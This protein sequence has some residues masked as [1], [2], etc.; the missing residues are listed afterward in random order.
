MNRW[1]TMWIMRLSW[2]C[3]QSP[4][5]ALFLHIPPYFAWSWINTYPYQYP[6]LYLYT[7][8]SLVREFGF[9]TTDGSSSKSDNT[10]M[11]RFTYEEKV[12]ECGI[13]PNE[14]DTEFSC[15]GTTSYIGEAPQI[16]D[17]M[18]IQHT[19][20]PGM[21]VD[22][23]AIDYAYV[24]DRIG[25]KYV[26]Y[27]LTDAW[28][29]VTCPPDSADYRNPECKVEL[30][31]NDK[32]GISSGLIMFNKANTKPNAKP[33]LPCSQTSNTARMS[34]F[35]SIFTIFCSFTYKKWENLK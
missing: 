26:R 33:I 14:V 11:V 32:F 34:V 28:G 2:K 9:H 15:N 13:V 8:G 31:L 5:S 10:M 29:G 19:G 27:I 35:I 3:R 4:E 22:G 21:A 18:F 17:S 25:E 12:Y 6:Y 16:D 23:V 30:V 24:I 7:A 1:K 20:M